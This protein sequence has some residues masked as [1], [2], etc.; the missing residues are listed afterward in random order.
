MGLR[1]RGRFRP[2]SLAGHDRWTGT[3]NSLAEEG[4]SRGSFGLPGPLSILRR[5]FSILAF[6]RGNER[7]GVCRSTRAL[8]GWQTGRRADHLV[9]VPAS[10]ERER[11]ASGRV[12][13]IGTEV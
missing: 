8:L 12:G 3:G 9:R 6:G 1:G 5:P 11:A 13:G 2:R 7:F 4:E 10:L